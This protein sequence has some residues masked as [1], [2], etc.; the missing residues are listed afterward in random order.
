MVIHTIL[1]VVLV[2]PALLSLHELGK[3]QGAELK[4]AEL[5]LALSGQSLAY[6]RAS[7]QAGFCQNRRGGL[8]LTRNAYEAPEQGSKY[9]STCNRCIYYLCCI[10]EAASSCLV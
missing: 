9:L 10:P 5:K 2:N 1:L 6:I 7:Q 8:I 3:L 4:I